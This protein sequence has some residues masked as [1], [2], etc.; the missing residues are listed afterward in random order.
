MR[1]G[2]VIVSFIA[3][4]LSVMTAACTGINRNSPA[5]KGAAV[6]ERQGQRETAAAE[7]RRQGSLPATGGN[8]I[9]RKVVPILMYHDIDIPKGPWKALFVNPAVFTAQLDWLKANGYTT[10]T[11]GDLYEHWRN[12]RP[13]PEKPIVL[14]FDDGY[15]SMF[16]TVLP[17]LKARNMKATFFL[18]LKYLN[19]PEGLETYMVEQLARDGMEIGSHTYNHVELT[20][21]STD[22]FPLEL[23]AS[24]AELE[25]ITKKPVDF[26]CYPIGR[27]NEKVYTAAAEYGYKGAVT[28]LFDN[29]KFEQDPYQWPRVRINY[30]DGVAGLKRKLTE[31]IP[32]TNFSPAYPDL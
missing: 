32:G 31:K 27:V 1:R 14:T 21:I 18:C 3:I 22:R 12:N 8:Y 23:G 4:L 5:T 17:L 10:I 9:L 29:A 16:Q 28:T 15:R 26:L 13:L 20:K 7:N 24:K 6:P 2:L 25:K 11:L 30:R 19:T